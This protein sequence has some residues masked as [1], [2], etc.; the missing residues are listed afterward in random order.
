MPL[1]FHHSSY[2]PDPSGFISTNQ[3]AKDY[4]A[5]CL[6]KN[7]GCGNRE[8]WCMEHFDTTVDPL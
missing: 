6:M 2:R 4:M 5:L 7:G 8:R 3:K 1:R